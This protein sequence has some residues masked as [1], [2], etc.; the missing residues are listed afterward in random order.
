M[1]D[2]QR[3]CRVLVDDGALG[4]AALDAEGQGRLWDRA[5][6]QSLHLYLAWRITGEAG[7]SWSEGLRRDARAVLADAAVLEE[8][9]RRE[10]LAVTNALARAGVQTLLLK[11]AALAYQVYPEPL[12]R[13]RDDTDLLIRPTDRDRAAEV[14]VGLGYDPAAENTADL[15][16]AQRHFRHADRGRFAHPIDVHWRVTNPLVFA[17]ALPFDRT[18]SRSVVIRALDP[19]RGPCAVDA[20]LLACLHRLAHHGDESSIHWVYDIHRLAATLTDQ[21]WGEV[22]EQAAANRLSGACLQG[23]SRSAGAFGT[24]IPAGV[25]ARL[26]AGARP[27]EQEFV[28]PHIGPLRMLA[29]DWRTLD[30]W[31]GRLRLLGAHVFPERAYMA[32]KYGTRNPILLPLL[33]AYRAL[34]GLPRWLAGW[35]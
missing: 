16:T 6:D 3:L 28:R 19:A 29:S 1:D 5:V 32:S 17:D 35:R 23:L 12:L 33:Y 30:S 18:W 31:S 4:H 22:V 10:L 11:G 9:Q 2:R 13:V 25:L 14:L 8:L 21:G 20:L 26:A 7:A 34:A 24:I 27:S 15:A